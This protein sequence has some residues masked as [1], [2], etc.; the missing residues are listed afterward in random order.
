[1]FVLAYSINMFI[2]LFYCIDFLQGTIVC[3]SIKRL[4]LFVFSCLGSFPCW[5]CCS[6]GTLTFLWFGCIFYVALWELFVLCVH[7]T[8]LGLGQ[9]IHG[10]WC[11]V[12]LIMSIFIFT[13]GI[14]SL[15]LWMCKCNC[16]STTPKITLESMEEV[17]TPS[18][19]PCIVC[20]ILNNENY[21]FFEK[22][23]SRLSFL[24]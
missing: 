14:P 6:A 5:L 15:D 17:I 10:W 9:A 2:C 4:G 23:L 20:T 1:M 21:Y 3:C 18:L 24:L 13:V 22:L 16:I 12:W 11:L 8:A 7:Q 19:L